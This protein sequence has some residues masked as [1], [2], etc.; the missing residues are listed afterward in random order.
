MALKIE[1][2]EVRLIC[3][4]CGCDQFEH[5]DADGELHEAPYE[6][7]LKCAHCGLETTKGELI[8]DNDETIQAAVDDI[9]EEATDAILKE[10][11]KAFR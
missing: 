1:P 5:D 6:S 9:T 10:L 7:V 4:G 3:R 2:R 11:R 8:E